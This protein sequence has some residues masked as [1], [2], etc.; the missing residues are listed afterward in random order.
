MAGPRL[1]QA[2]QDFRCLRCEASQPIG[3]Y[4]EGCPAC[5]AQGHAS[6]LV[7]TYDPHLAGP[8]EQR[9]PL[10]GAPYLGEGATPLLPL[11]GIAEELEMDGV[12]LKAEGQNP[13]GSHKDRMSAQVVARAAMLGAPRVLAAST[14]NA[15]VSLAAYAAHAGLAC[16][17]L[18]R[19]GLGGTWARDMA[20]LGAELVA[21]ATADERWVR[22]GE[23]VRAGDGYP[24]TNY[25]TPPVGSNPFGVQGYKAVGHELAAALAP[26]PPDA[27]L[28]PTARGDL[29]WGIWEG[30]REA[31]GSRQ[32]PPPKMI[33]VEP[34]PRSAK[35]LAGADYRGSFPGT[36]DQ[37]AIASPSVTW[38]IVHALRASGGLAID[39]GDAEAAAAHAELVK[40]GIALERCA[41]APLI[42]LRRLRA[43]GVLPAGSRAVLIATSD[44][45]REDPLPN[46]LL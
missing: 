3:D 21:V 24:A 20:E 40:L 14:G 45:R 30:W 8:P 16:T 28:V 4:F 43:R 22:M 25:M 42:A 35:A 46:T 37:V 27:V 7:A 17:I 6:S 1:N 36:T 33:A 31:C 12:W 5:A 23:M 44:G 29:L 32:P 13:T 34:F 10:L 19:A 18:I 11:R 41:A 39:V 9:M 26:S 38:Q 15:G 2:L